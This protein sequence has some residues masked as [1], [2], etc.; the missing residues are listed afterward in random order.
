[1]VKKTQ[2][3]GIA[4]TRLPKVRETPGLIQITINSP[5]T[6]APARRL[7][8]L[9]DAALRSRLAHFGAHDANEL[10]ALRHELR[11]DRGQATITESWESIANCMHFWHGFSGS[12]IRTIEWT[13]EHC[14]APHRDDV[15]ASVGESFLRAC[16]C[17][18]VKRITVTTRLVP[19]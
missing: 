15:G 8:N 1:M 5:E 2:Q 17:G 11:K 12:Q 19:A 10:A 4:L 3:F 7:G 13:C 18:E 14:A 9:T 6:G 16:K